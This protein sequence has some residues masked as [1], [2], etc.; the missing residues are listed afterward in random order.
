MKVKELIEHLQDEDP[1]QEVMLAYP[2]GDY[3][4]STVANSVLSVE[5]LPLEWSDYHEKYQL[6]RDLEAREVEGCK[7]FVVLL[8]TRLF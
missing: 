5:E 4:R 2:A 6:P 7:N 1:E 8:T 3:W